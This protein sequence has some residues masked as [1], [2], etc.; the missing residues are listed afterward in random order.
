VVDMQSTDQI[1]GW[2]RMSDSVN[3]PRWLAAWQQQNNMNCLSTML[4]LC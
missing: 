1:I 3:R 4:M 2:V